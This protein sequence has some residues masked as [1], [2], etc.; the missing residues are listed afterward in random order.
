MV[1]GESESGHVSHELGASGPQMSGGSRPR[2]PWCREVP[3][4]GKRKLHHGRSLARL[5]SLRHDVARGEQRSVK[6]LSTPLGVLKAGP[7][8]SGARKGNILAP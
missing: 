3:I 2:Q 5:R 6:I 4:A 1:P 8:D 7:E